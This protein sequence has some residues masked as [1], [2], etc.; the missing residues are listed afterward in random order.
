MTDYL[1][2]DHAIVANSTKPVLFDNQINL[3]KYLTLYYHCN[4]LF[5]LLFKM[6]AIS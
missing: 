1:V 3:I 2:H 4:Y 6:A 5:L